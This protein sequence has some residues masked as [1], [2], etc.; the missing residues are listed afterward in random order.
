MQSPYG[1]RM[2]RVQSRRACRTNNRTSRASSGKSRYA[3][4]WLTGAPGGL[5]SW[6]PK[7]GPTCT[8]EAKFF[9]GCSGIISK[10]ELRQ[11]LIPDHS[12][13]VG[14]PPQSSSPSA[15][16]IPKSKIHHRTA[17][18]SPAKAQLANSKLGIRQSAIALAT[19][20][21]SNESEFSGQHPPPLHYIRVLHPHHR[22]QG[23]TRASLHS[24]FTP[25]PPQSRFHTR[26][27]A[28]G[29]HTHTTAVKV[30]HPFRCIRTSH[31]H[32][33]SQG[34]TPTPLHSGFTPRVSHP[35]RCI[36]VLHPGFHTRTTAVRVSYPLR[37]IR[38]SH[39]G[40]HTQKAI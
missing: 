36:R 37:C 21:I 19:T 30:S 2:I 18:A 22:S 9:T 25:T 40:F 3:H 27:A 5:V 15:H 29:L 6:P 38:V 10:Q 13:Y 8:V 17:W 1:I 35:L 31:P 34:F 26:S 14:T 4:A 16:S 24:G 28:F 33:R 32:H 23:F 7:M 12:R 11:T 20:S 39:P